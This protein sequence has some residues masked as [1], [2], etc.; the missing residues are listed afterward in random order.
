MVYWGKNSSR[1]GEVLQVRTRDGCAGQT[2]QESGQIKLMTG[3]QLRGN[4]RD[5]EKEELNRMTYRVGKGVE[6]TRSACIY[7]PFGTSLRV[8][9]V[10]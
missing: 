10:V 5:T 3:L 9:C 1:G 6:G 8:S 2:G 4:R 7:S